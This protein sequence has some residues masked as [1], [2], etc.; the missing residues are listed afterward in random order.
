[1]EHGEVEPQETLTEADAFAAA[2][3]LI[4]RARSARKAAGERGVASAAAKKEAALGVAAPLK[5]A[6]FASLQPLLVIENCVMLAVPWGGDTL[7]GA[8]AA[9]GATAHK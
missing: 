1:M 6:A 7:T 9:N 2:G 5:M 8:A 4:K 3:S